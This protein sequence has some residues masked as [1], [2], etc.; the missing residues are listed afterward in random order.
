MRTR[1]LVHVDSEVDCTKWENPQASGSISTPEIHAFVVSS[2]IGVETSDPTWLGGFSTSIYFH[3]YFTLQ[4]Q[5]NWHAMEQ[6]CSWHLEHLVV[7]IG[8]RRG[9]FF[10]I[11]RIQL[12]GWTASDFFWSA[13]GAMQLCV[14]WISNGLG[15]KTGAWWCSKQGNKLVMAHMAG[16]WLARWLG[17]VQEVFLAEVVHHFQ[18]WHAPRGHGVGKKHVACEAL[19]ACVSE[20]LE[21]FGLEREQRERDDERQT[22][23]CIGGHLRTPLDLWTLQSMTWH[24][25]S[26]P[27][28]PQL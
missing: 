27:G 7:A 25:L 5:P 3:T 22:V 21:G 8:L 9:R 13:S 23:T 2:F 12:L 14:P 4:L 26:G 1:V 10:R 16:E 15:L 17:Q 20:L 18:D 28:F 6:L 11:L 19:D 24:D